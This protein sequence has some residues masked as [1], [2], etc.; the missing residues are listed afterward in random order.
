MMWVLILILFGGPM[1]QVQ[2][3]VTLEVHWSDVQ[4]CNERLQDAVE[5]GLPP[6]ST[7]ACVNIGNILSA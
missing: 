7:I 2:E 1:E 4:K 6:R 3:V 5:A